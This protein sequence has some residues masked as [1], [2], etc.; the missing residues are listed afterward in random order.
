MANLDAV[1]ILTLIDRIIAYIHFYWVNQLKRLL[2]I[3]IAGN[4]INSHTAQ[5]VLVELNSFELSFF[6]WVQVTQVEL[7][8]LNWVQAT[9]LSLLGQF[10][11][12]KK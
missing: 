4:N 2:I 5:F 12:I 8:F 9:R 6:N 11:T 3:W 1:K 7:S 10:F